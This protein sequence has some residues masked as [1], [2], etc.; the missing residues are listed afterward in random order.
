[1]QQNNYSKIVHNLLTA[2]VSF[3][4]EESR[5]TVL[6]ISKGTLKEL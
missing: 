2:T 5:E 4:I 6:D 1:M 3:I